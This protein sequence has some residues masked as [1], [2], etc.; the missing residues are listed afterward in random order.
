MRFSNCPPSGTLFGSK[1]LK[2]RNVAQAL[3]RRWGQ[4]DSLLPAELWG[5]VGDFAR[6][7]ECADLLD[8]LLSPQSKTA[9]FQKRVEIYNAKYEKNLKMFWGC[10]L[11]SVTA[12]GFAS[13]EEPL[14]SVLAGKLSSLQRSLSPAEYSFLEKSVKEKRCPQDATGELIKKVLNNCKLQPVFS[15][16]DGLVY[17]PV[18]EVGKGKQYFSLVVKEIGVLKKLVTLEFQQGKVLSGPLD[19]SRLR[20]LYLVQIKESGLKL[21]DLDL[22]GSPL[23]ISDENPVAKPFRGDSLAMRICHCFAR[24]FYG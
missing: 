12:P 14:H 5:L 9:D 24:I 22:H 11:F 21:T 10:V 4:V 1:G 6:D 3:E 16:A 15:Q 20:H 17:A 7:D 18:R 13:G 8:P 2:E 19:L 23:V